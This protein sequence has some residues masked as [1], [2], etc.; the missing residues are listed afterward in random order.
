M[1]LEILRGLRRDNRV[2]IVVALTLLGAADC[3]GH[4]PVPHATCEAPQAIALLTPQEQ[5]AWVKLAKW[6]AHWY[7]AGWL[8]C[9]SR[10]S[11]HSAVPPFPSF[12]VEPALS[13]DIR[14]PEVGAL[15]V[16]GPWSLTEWNNRGFEQCR[17][18]LLSSCDVFGGTPHKSLGCGDELHGPR[19]SDINTQGFASW[20]RR[21]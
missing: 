2:A 18:L 14:N 16:H 6:N 7:F 12:E 21:G 5:A 20:R 17:F 13:T 10:F 15:T 19:W 9:W 1:R 8:N 3:A 11:N 4:E